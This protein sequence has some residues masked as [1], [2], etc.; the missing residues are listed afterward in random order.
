MSTETTE[1]EFVKFMSSLNSCLT[2][3]LTFKRPA[4]TL[5]RT[6][7]MIA[8]HLQLVSITDRGKTAANVQMGTLVRGSLRIRV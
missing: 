3:N 8:I 5:A 4:V 6:G 7:F 2:F 1:R